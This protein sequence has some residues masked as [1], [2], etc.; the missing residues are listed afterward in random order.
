[1]KPYVLFLGL[2]IIAAACNNAKP[3]PISTDLTKTTV[4]D[5]G[6]RDSV[7]NNDQK[8]YNS[9]TVS[10]PCVKCLIEVIKKT[11][12]YQKIAGPV[13][14]S[15]LIYNVNWVKAGNPTNI[16]NGGKITNGMQVDVIKKNGANQQKLSSYVYSDKDSTLYV[17]DTHEK[18]EKD[19]LKI[20]APSLKKIR[21]A[22]FWGVAS[23]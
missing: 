23:N 11:D 8:N 18:Y 19:A 13:P 14:D 5:S 1:M 12:S 2:A 3:K 10:G 20:D 21:N 16:D 17:I 15:T 7:I 22:C 4:T 9:A 6:R